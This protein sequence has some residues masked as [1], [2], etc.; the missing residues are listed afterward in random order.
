MPKS[1]RKVKIHRKTSETDIKISLNLDGTGKGKIRTGIPFL[2]H[3]LMAFSRHGFF[4]LEVLAKGDLDIDIHHT[5]EDVG[6]CLGEA[7]KKAVKDKKGINRFGFY[8]V[9][10][11]EALVRVVID[12]S[13]RASL[14]FTGKGLPKSQKIHTMHKQYSFNYLKQ[15]LYAF[16]VHSGINMNVG[17]ECGEDSHHMIEAT[18]K[19]LGR[20]L[21]MAVTK[22]KNVLGIP[23]TKGQL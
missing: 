18:F 8:Y 4:D 3:M 10:M 11:D 13:G 20:S 2:D 7:V 9:P 22:N 19:A 12:M 23:S 1:Q 17:V 5:N 14:H 6:I 21:N 15:F 16:C